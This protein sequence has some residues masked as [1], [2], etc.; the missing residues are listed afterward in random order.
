M[1]LLCVFVLGLVF[2]LCFCFCFM[3]NSFL[4]L[5]FW[6]W[7]VV[8]VSWSGGLL[9]SLRPQGFEGWSG[10]GWPGLL[11]FPA[12][13]LFYRLFRGWCHLSWKG[14]RFD[15]CAVLRGWLYGVLEFDTVRMGV[16][17]DN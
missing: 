4:V 1:G 16:L 9:G 11:G 2:A 3:A 7:V 14:H 17:G 6:F 5:R 15:R 13:W 10:L 8:V 12:L